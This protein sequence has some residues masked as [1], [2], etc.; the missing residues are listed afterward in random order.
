MCALKSLEKRNWRVRIV[1]SLLSL[2]SKT[3]NTNLTQKCLNQEQLLVRFVFTESETLL[4]RA[5][6]KHAC[7]LCSVKWSFYSSV[8]CVDATCAITHCLKIKHF[9]VK[10]FWSKSNTLPSCC[11]CFCEIVKETKQR[12][13][14]ILSHLIKTKNSDFSWIVLIASL[15]NFPRFSWTPAA[16]S[17][18][19]SH[20]VSTRRRPLRPLGVTPFTRCVSAQVVRSTCRQQRAAPPARPW[21]TSAC[22]ADL[23]GLPSRLRLKLLQL[24]MRPEKLRWWIQEVLEDSSVSLVFETQSLFFYFGIAVDTECLWI[25]EKK[26]RNHIRNVWMSERH[27]STNLSTSPPSWCLLK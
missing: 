10:F 24:L 25:G 23:G 5:I 7:Q 20:L 18:A 4:W 3:Q 26:K 9:L 27:E 8:L 2:H 15:L 6:L 16:F 14:K 21:A 17:W 1:P 11:L 13:K 19:T 12:E 22:G